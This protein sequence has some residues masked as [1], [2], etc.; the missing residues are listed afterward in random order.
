MLWC[1]FP[2]AS[3]TLTLKVVI[4]AIESFIEGELA[5]RFQDQQNVDE[6]DFTVQYVDMGRGLRWVRQHTARRVDLLLC[7]FTATPHLPVAVADEFYLRS[8]ENFGKGLNLHRSTS[9]CPQVLCL[10]KSYR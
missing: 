6:M 9:P 1:C 7:F 2:Q 5:K 4:D 10:A 3:A 8:T